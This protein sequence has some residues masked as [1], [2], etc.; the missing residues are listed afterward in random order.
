MFADMGFSEEAENVDFYL[1]VLYLK[2]L[3]TNWNLKPVWSKNTIFIYF[4]RLEATEGRAFVLSVI[5]RGCIAN[6]TREGGVTKP[7]KNI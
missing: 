5:Q 3:S 7:K 6:V 1:K 4:L 2:K